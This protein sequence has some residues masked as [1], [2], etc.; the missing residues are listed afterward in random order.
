MTAK[1]QR[2]RTIASAITYRVTSTVL[3]AAISWLV[4]GQWVESLIVTLSF[5]LLATALYYFNDR[6]W[7][8]TD[9]GRKA[10][11][12][13]VPEPTPFRISPSSKSAGV[14]G[15]IPLAREFLE[16]AS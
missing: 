3:L 5:A 1:T 11:A 14:A 13:A 7:E 9:W 16:E 2:K 4:T 8:R 6:A 12:P 15:L 10:G